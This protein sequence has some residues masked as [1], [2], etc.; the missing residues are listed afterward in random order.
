MFFPPAIS[1]SL[2]TLKGL[3]APQGSS[4]HTTS[5]VQVLSMSIQLRMVLGNEEQ[6]WASPAGTAHEFFPQ[7]FWDNVTYVT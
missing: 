5:S 6:P 2:Q 1:N 3:A 7:K 4:S